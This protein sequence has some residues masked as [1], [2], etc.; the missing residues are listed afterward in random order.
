M[1]LELDYA[2]GNVLTLLSETSQLLLLGELGFEDFQVGGGIPYLILDLIVLLMMVFLRFFDSNI[3]NLLFQKRVFHILKLL[4]N[5]FDS[6]AP[7]NI[8]KTNKKLT[9]LT[10]QSCQNHLQDF[11]TPLAKYLCYGSIY[12]EVTR[13]IYL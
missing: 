3:L 9:F 10:H 7:N 5:V 4:K 11:D 6:R 1:G 8:Y 13:Q 12:I 2:F